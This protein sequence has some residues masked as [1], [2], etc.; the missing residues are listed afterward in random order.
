MP[1]FRHVATNAHAVQV[2]QTVTEAAN[3]FAAI[4]NRDNTQYKIDYGDWSEVHLAGEV[5]SEI[6]GCGVGFDFDAAME[7]P[8][9]RQYYCKVMAVLAKV[10]IYLLYS[11]SKWIL[12]KERR[13]H[14]VFRYTMEDMLRQRPHG[15]P[16]AT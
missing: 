6:L 15:F 2:P 5:V 16:K 13:D 9:Y 3:V 12:R 8:A 7:N 11:P 10:G 1:V 4:A 14:L